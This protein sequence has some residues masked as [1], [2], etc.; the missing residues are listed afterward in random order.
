MNEENKTMSSTINELKS[1][2][3]DAKDKCDKLNEANR[4]L[5][6]RTVKIKEYYTKIKIDYD[7]L[8]VANKLLSCKTHK[9][10]NPA[11]KIDVAT[12]CDDLRQDDQTSLHDELT[13]KV[14]VLTLDNQKL[15]RY[16]TDA[17]TRGKVA[18]ES[19]DINNELAV[20]N[21]RLINE[22]KKLK[23]ENEHLA[24]SVQKFN[25]GQYLQNELLM[26]TVMKN[27]KSG[28]GYNSFLQ[29]KATSQYK[30]KQTPKPIKYFECGK[31]GHFAHSCKA[32]ALKNI[33]FQCSLC[34]KKSSKWKS[35]SYIPRSTK[36]E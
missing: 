2:P 13:E 12:S 7:N 5:K 31:E 23:N 25:K 16:L 33:C 15:K 35:Q 22:V 20:D 8:L 14:E 9:A 6:D 4:D 21:E 1:S 34:S 32:K 28:I 19:N 29:K 11:V 24:T 30:A 17:T 27:N 3:K 18:I 36:Q 26:N 10:I